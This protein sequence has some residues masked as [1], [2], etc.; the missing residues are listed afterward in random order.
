[1]TL[2]VSRFKTDNIAKYL[3]AMSRVCL[4]WSW[5]ET[6]K[7][8]KIWFLPFNSHEVH[9]RDRLARA[10]LCKA[11]YTSWTIAFCCNRLKYLVV[12]EEP[13]GILNLGESC[14]GL[15]KGPYFVNECS[16]LRG[17]SI[18]NGEKE[19]SSIIA[20]WSLLALFKGTFRW[21]HHPKYYYKRTESQWKKPRKHISHIYISW[22]YH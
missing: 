8:T 1:M 10:R 3:T 16:Q 17:I 14:Y 6:I 11:I 7:Q 18:G 21:G 20:S 2:L 22:T 9:R 15:W 19:I 13:L 5:I 12:P 4:N